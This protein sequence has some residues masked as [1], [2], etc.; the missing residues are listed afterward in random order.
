MKT[1]VK[2]TVNTLIGILF[3]KICRT[4]FMFATNLLKGWDVYNPDG[5]IL[6]PFGITLMLFA[7]VWLILTAIRLITKKPSFIEP[8]YF[9][10]GLLID[11]VFDIVY[12][13]IQGASLNSLLGIIF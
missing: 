2:N 13:M 1:A 3:V 10:L 8:A 5:D 11:A 7:L 4:G 9:E 12:A 6:I